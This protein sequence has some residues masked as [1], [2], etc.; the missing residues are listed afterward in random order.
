MSIYESAVKKP[1]T[2][3][4]IFVAI[5]VLGLFSFTRLSVDLYPKIELNQITVMTTYSGASAADI[6]QNVTKRLETALSTVTDLKKITSNSKDNI[7]LVVLEFEYGTSMDEAVNDIRSVIDLQRNFLPDECESPVILKFSSDMMPVAFLSART[8]SKN[9]QGLYKILEDKVANPINRL[10][11]VA[12]V[13][14]SGAPQRE[15]Q[16]LADPRK[17][18]AYRVTVEQLAA[19]I[20]AENRNVPGG[21]IDVGTQTYSVRVDGEF[22]ASDELNDIVIGSFNGKNIYVKDVATIKDTLKERSTEVFTNGV[23]GSS[24]VIQ[25][26]SGANVVEIADRIKAALPEI[27]NTLPEDIKLDMILDTS[28][29]IKD[30]ISSLT[31]TVVLAGVFVML[32]VLFFLGRWRATVIIILTIPV[33]LVAAFIYLMVTGNTLNIISLSSLSIAIGMVVDD[34]IVVLENI[35]THIERGSKPKDA[36]IYATNEVAVAV[37]ASTLTIIAVFFPLTMVTGLAGIMFKQ[38]GWIVTIIIAVSTYAALT[39]TPMLASKMMRKDPKRSKA[40][41]YI[42]APIEKFLN[43]LDRVYVSTLRYSLKHRFTVIIASFL[44]FVSSIFLVFLV[45]ADFFPATDNSQIGINVELPVGTRVEQA[46]KLNNYLYTKWKE[47]Y[48]EVEVYQS[49]MGQSDGSNVFMSMRN[50]G[51]HLITYTARLVKASE[52][53]RDIFE[54]SDEIRKDLAEIPE[55]YRYEVIPGGSNGGMGSGG[56]TYEMNVLGYNMDDAEKVA[57]KVSEIMKKTEGLRDVKLSREDYMPQ[58]KVVFDRK[59]LAMN[60]ISLTSAASAVRNRINGII[61]SK[62][63]E[64]GEEYDIVVRNDL[65]NRQSIEDIENILIYNSQGKSV[66]LAEVGS[67]IEGFAP[68]TIEHLDRERVIK[69]SGLIYKRALGDIAKDVN[70]EVAK[71]QLPP[72]IAVKASGTIEDQQDSFRDMF[73]LL[74]LVIMLVYIVMAA[75]FESFRDP[76]IIMTSILFAFTGVFFALWLTNTPLSLIALIGGVMLVGIVVKNGIVLID[77]INLNRERGMSV[78]RGVLNGGNSRLRPV[79]M[80]TATTILGMVPMAM[81]IGEGSETWQPMGIAIIGGLTL[82]TFLTLIVV[83]T[84]YASFHIGDI[85][86]KRRKMAKQKWETTN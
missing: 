49:M 57:K 27:Q 6:E 54:I 58:L 29:F 21:N 26:Q 73:T 22:S 41:S 85:K 80:T 83:P 45:G 63:R 9:V 74:I 71:L 64:A 52:R 43:S 56:S 76:F 42:Y 62:F 68:P 17:M 3:A 39:L 7:S 4:L 23:L 12:S 70:K 18:E 66:R 10:D 60:N 67:V 5:V 20:S 11:G 8:S 61:T 32:V 34:A 50:S 75:Q 37:I 79:L 16:V 78:M 44:M 86:R 77:Y 82:S 55:I 47:K 14:I 65:K 53:E 40:F 19:V 33:S 69:V 28:E 84:I 1:V 81:G 59:K 35:T 15:I 36:A 13:S 48:P 72:M 30:S 38:L 24:I 25:K 2:T 51:T 46:R 31:E